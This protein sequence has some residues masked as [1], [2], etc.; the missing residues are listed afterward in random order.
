MAFKL[1]AVGGKSYIK[2]YM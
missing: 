1:T 2:R